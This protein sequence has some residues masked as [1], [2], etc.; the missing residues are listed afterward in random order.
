MCNKQDVIISKL[1]GL[2]LIDDMFLF[3]E[4]PDALSRLRSGILGFR[5]EDRVEQMCHDNKWTYENHVKR[6][7]PYD[8]IINSLKVQVKSSGHVPGKCDL[9]RRPR[10]NQPQKNRYRTDEIDILVA[11]N[12]H[13]RRIYVIPTKHLVDVTEPNYL[14]SYV[15]WESMERYEDAWNYVSDSTEESVKIPSVFDGII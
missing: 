12:L 5:L 15:K 10:P 1:Q 8:Y 7:L 13:D 9:T 3:L 14:V 4:R 2:G 6:S 11:Q